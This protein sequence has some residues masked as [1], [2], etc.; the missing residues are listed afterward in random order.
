M[1]MTMMMMMMM[2]IIIIMLIVMMVMVM[3]T[4]MVMMI[5]GVSPGEELRPHEVLHEEVLRATPL[6]CCTYTALTLILRFSCASD[7]KD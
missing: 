1:T 4:M 2:I 6:T 5:L 3:V 7:L